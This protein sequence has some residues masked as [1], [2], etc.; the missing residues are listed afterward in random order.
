MKKIVSLLLV[1][2]LA[3]TLSTAVFAADIT[4][5]GGLTGE[6]YDV[7][8]IF[9]A[10]SSDTNNDGKIDENDAVAYSI[11]SDSTEGA[12]VWSFF[13]SGLTAVNGVYTNSTY[14]LTFTP[15]ASDTTR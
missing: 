1:V 10:T 4:I 7:Y 3:I 2:L 9:D 6:T 15:S 8:K 5:D 11:D 12:P 14:G 13:T